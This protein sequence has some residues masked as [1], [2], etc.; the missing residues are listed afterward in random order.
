M[1]RKFRIL[2]VRIASLRIV[3]AFSSKIRF[4]EVK[5]YLS[6]TLNY[7]LIYSLQNAGAFPRETETI[8]LKEVFELTM[9]E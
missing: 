4:L 5:L 2:E 9:F 6:K 8:Y 3:E 1:D 7:L